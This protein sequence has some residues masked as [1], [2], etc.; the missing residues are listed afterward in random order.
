MP[1][2]RPSLFFLVIV[3]RVIFEKEGERSTVFLFALPS[4]YHHQTKQPVCAVSFRVLNHLL[5]PL[6]INVGEFSCFV[7]FVNNVLVDI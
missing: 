5:P 2:P 1:L 4:Q 7:L 6:S 3:G